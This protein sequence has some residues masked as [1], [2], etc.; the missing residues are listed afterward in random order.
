[1]T[2]KILAAPEAIVDQ[3][4]ED[5][6]KRVLGLPCH[7]RAEA[8][9]AVFTVADLLS[10]CPGYLVRSNQKEGSPVIVKVNGEAIGLGEL[11]A[12]EDALAIRLTELV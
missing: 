1:M 2:E 4:S 11:D 3:P 9:I 8:P 10:L 12:V 7:F 6:W 5:P